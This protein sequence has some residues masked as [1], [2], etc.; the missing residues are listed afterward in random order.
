MEVPPDRMEKAMAYYV[1]DV[2]GVTHHM[3]DLLE[4]RRYIRNAQSLFPVYG[5]TIWRKQKGK[6]VKHS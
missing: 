1:R 2:K 6:W 3:G 5:M 4:C